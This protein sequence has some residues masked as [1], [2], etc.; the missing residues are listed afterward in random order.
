MGGELSHESAGRA[1]DD[2][3]RMDLDL[4]DLIGDLGGRERTPGPRAQLVI[5]TIFGL[6]LVGLSVAGAW[7]IWGTSGGVPFRAAAV[8]MFA[9]LAIFGLVTIILARKSR[10]PGCLFGLS[11][12]GLFVTRI[13]FGP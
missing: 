2:N 9:C 13:V 5:R 6:L 7:K 12:A 10:W 1:L 3:R 11:F 4:D 8:V